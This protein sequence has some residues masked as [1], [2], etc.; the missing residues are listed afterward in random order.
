MADPS[1]TLETTEVSQKPSS[2][3]RKHSAQLDWM[4]TI[5][6]RIPHFAEQRLKEPVSL[7]V[8]MGMLSLLRICRNRNRDLISRSG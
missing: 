6:S 8:T 2:R 4:A 5:R 1:V 7:E 3:R